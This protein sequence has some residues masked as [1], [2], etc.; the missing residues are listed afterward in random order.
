MGSLLLITACGGG[1]GDATPPAPAAKLTVNPSPVTASANINSMDA[2][3]LQMNIAA[4]NLPADAKFFFIAHSS[5]GLASVSAQPLNGATV[6][7]DIAFKEARSLTPGEYDDTIDMKFC[8]ESPCVRVVAGTPTAV[9]V[10]YTVTPATGANA[11]NVSFNPSSVVAQALL[12]DQYGPSVPEVGIDLGNFKVT[13]YVEVHS[14]GVA[15]RNPTYSIRDSSHSALFMFLANPRE[16]GKGAFHD[17]I[18][19]KMCFDT[20]CVNPVPGTPFILAVDYTVTDTVTG[21]GGDARIQV[22]DSNA[23]DLAWDAQRQKF[24][25]LLSND[26]GAPNYHFYIAVLDPSTGLLGPKTSWEATAF[27]IELSDDGA[28]LYAPLSDMPAI[29]R[30]SVPDMSLQPLITLP[31]DGIGFILYAA[32]VAVAP[33]AA[34]TIAIAMSGAPGGGYPNGGVAIFDDAAQRPNAAVGD[35][36][37]GTGPLADYIEWGQDAST[38]YGTGETWSQDLF[39]IAVNGSG[40]SASGTVKNVGP[41]RIHFGGGLIYMDR[42]GKVIDP[43]TGTVVAT[44]GNGFTVG[45]LALDLASQRVFAYGAGPAGEQLI[46][47][48]D[49]PSLS[50]QATLPL[51]N[52]VLPSSQILRWA[53]NGLAYISYG[54]IVLITGAFVAP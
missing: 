48:F 18:S 21:A 44:I 49:L 27:E 6:T 51:V 13:P 9:P 5:N 33:A 50:E 24:Y 53:A 19:L 12:Y 38:L 22:I 52:A 39:T 54:K 37:A 14:T 10:K 35:V 23:V 26:P 31:R 43:A 28:L 41:G 47:R 16:I 34:H 32:D 46:K 11:V 30:M 25:V 8:L 29:A 4:S 40:A 1:G 15:V 17:T 36:Q 7:I 20:Q 3:T 2:P 42:G 45:R